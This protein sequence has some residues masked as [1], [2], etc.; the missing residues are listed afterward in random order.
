MTTTT[1]LDIALGKALLQGT[2]TVL[3][4]G[5][6]GLGGHGQC[7]GCHHWRLEGRLGDR[8]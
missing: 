8:G 2:V 3:A 4:T 1:T 5:D 6:A 7:L